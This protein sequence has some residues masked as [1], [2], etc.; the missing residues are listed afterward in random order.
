LTQ[1][2]QGEVDVWV[3]DL[4]QVEIS[5]LIACLSSEELARADRFHFSR[6]RRRYIGVRG[7]LRVILGNYLK[8]EPQSIEF[9]NLKHGKP[10]VY[11]R[12]GLEFNVS[13]SH[14]MAMV[15]VTLKHLIGVDIEYIQRKV[16]LEGLAKRFFSP[17]E[18]DELMSLDENSRLIGF[19]NAWTRKEAFIKAI[20]A[21]LSYPLSSF[22]VSLSP[23]APAKL[24]W[25]ENSQ[26]KAQSWCVSEI[27]LQ[28][29]YQ[30]AIAVQMPQINTLRH[31][32]FP[33]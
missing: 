13:H 33:D 25:L 1:I 19:F 29:N 31:L 11:N 10:Y 8:C 4:D 16:D 12:L 21:G 23:N 3:I 24:L 14:E 27:P 5:S 30:G 32:S 20:G 26:E 9:T 6:D 15:G 7:A 22:T 17:Q 28:D 2:K 18:V